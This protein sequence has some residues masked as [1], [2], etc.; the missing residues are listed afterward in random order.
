M[1][2]MTDT[3]MACSL[4]TSK[5]PTISSAQLNA[6]AQTG[7]PLQGLSAVADPMSRKVV[8]V[9]DRGAISRAAGIIK[10]L[11]VVLCH[12]GVKVQYVPG[13]EQLGQCVELGRTVGR[14]VQALMAGEKV[15]SAA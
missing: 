6:I 10:E 4:E 13:H 2:T 12:P 9:G 5:I 11:D 1:L 7:G 8:V 15:E 14:A 3:I